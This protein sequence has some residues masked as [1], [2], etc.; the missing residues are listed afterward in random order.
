MSSKK[1]E[2]YEVS[3]SQMRIDIYEAGHAYP[4]EAPDVIGSTSAINSPGNNKSHTIV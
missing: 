4:S 3:V 1:L 2:R